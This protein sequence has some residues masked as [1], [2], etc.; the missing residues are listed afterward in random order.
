[1]LAPSP[2][3]EAHVLS[4]RAF[5]VELEFRSAGFWRE[6]ETGVPGGKP[7]GAEKEPTTNLAHIW[8]ELPQKLINMVFNLQAHTEHN[9]MSP[10]YLKS[11]N[12]DIKIEPAC[13]ILHQK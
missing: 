7:L 8:T 10:L 9:K 13:K 11:S 3:P 2:E 4:V 6:G 12:F 1:M 5:Q